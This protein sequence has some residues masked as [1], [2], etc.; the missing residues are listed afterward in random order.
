MV[1]QALRIS[2]D[3]YGNDV[4]S[5]SELAKGYT[6]PVQPGNFPVQVPPE[7][8]KAHETLLAKRK[9]TKNFALEGYQ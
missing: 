1:Q 9:L 7:I 4:M 5:A 2:N 3:L 8:R 6:R